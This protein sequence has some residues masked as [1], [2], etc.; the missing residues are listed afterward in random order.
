LLPWISTFDAFSFVF[1]LSCNTFWI[2]SFTV[3]AWVEFIWRGNINYSIV[4]PPRL[5]LECW[6]LACLRKGGS[7]PNLKYQRELN[8]L[9]F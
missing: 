9:W 6:K 8:L 5:E 2:A 7:S 3:S 1:C 4:G